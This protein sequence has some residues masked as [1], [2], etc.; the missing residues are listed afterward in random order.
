MPI[1]G[2][3]ADYE[4]HLKSKNCSK[5]HIRNVTAQIRA[6]DVERFLVE[7]RD[8]FGCSVET[9]N[10]YLRAIKAFCRWMHLNKRIIEHPLLSLKNLN[11]RVDRRHDRRALSKDEFQRL[12]DVA[13]TGPPVEGLLGIDRAVLYLIA[14]YTGL[15]KGEIG[16]LTKESFNLNNEKYAT[17][18][19]DAC[20]SKH[21]RKD[22]LP[23]HP[24]LVEKLKNWLTID[25]FG[26]RKTGEIGVL[27][28]Q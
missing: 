8:E 12:L 15:R 18:T 5:C 2:H 16:S 25:L 1:A 4:K 27:V 9:S 13:E 26:N 3:L 22:V 21:R 19:V 20:Y 6:S 23:L 24:S 11:V 28:K 10:H 7:L 17:V 14:G